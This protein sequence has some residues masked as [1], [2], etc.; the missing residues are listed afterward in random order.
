MHG[1]RHTR[2]ARSGFTLIEL[3]IAI[4]IVGLVAGSLVGVLD[5][6]RKTYNQGSAQTRVQADARRALDRI[7]AEL[8]NVGL[9]TLVPAPV[10]VAVNDLVFQVATGVNAANSAI[11]FGSSTR[12]RFAYEAGE[13][14]NGVDDDGDGLV[15]EGRVILTRNYLQANEVSVTLVRGVSEYLQGEFANGADDNG[16]G[17]AD[18]KGFCM[19]LQGNL[20]IL[21]LSLE[22]PVTEGRSAV[23]TVETAVRLKN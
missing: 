11:T 1:P 13:T 14:N 10:G 22:R 12:L 15:D 5:S 7:A 19:T 21:R 16:N 9:A 6:T 20:L 3:A 18:E 17:F 2:A 4:G 8:E 23:A